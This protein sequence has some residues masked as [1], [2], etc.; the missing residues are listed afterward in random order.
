MAGYKLTG[1]GTGSAATDSATLGQVQSNTVS[2]IGSIS[3]TNTITGSLSPAI[4]A[5]ASG[6]MFWFVAA[7]DNTGAVT[8]NVNSLGAKNVTK[9]GSTALTAG[10][11]KS[12]QTVAVIYDGTRFQIVNPVV[13]GLTGL[14]DSSNTAL[15]VAAFDSNT[16]SAQNVA[17]GVDALTANNNGGANVALGYKAL[18]AHTNQGGGSA[19]SYSYNTGI[20]HEAGKAI[21]TG[22][23]NTMLGGATGGGITTGSYNSALGFQSYS[24]GN[25]SNSTCVGA[26]SAVTGSNQVQ[27]GDSATTTYAY[28]TV[29]NRSDERDKADIQ[30]TQLGLNFVMALRPRDYKWDMRE[31]YKPPKPAQDAPE[32][33]W[34]A[35]REACR[36]ANLAHNGT[37]KRNRYHHGLIAQEVKQT[38]DALGVDF[39]GYQD[40]T[41]K[42]GDAVLTIGYGELIA[43]LIKAIQELKAEFDAYKASHP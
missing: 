14:T 21:T 13:I 35:W 4:T 22:Y 42:G 20:G 2:L 31:D 7:A 16:S 26:S 28:G 5:Y 34:D 38:M 41:I 18:E 15:G 39:G 6:Q 19:G 1:L 24:T 11:I 23:V 33:E 27:L 32:S 10:E 37:H 12:G 17:I 30:D 29:Q 43:P 8:L 9:N 36:L 3:G 25:Y 40:H